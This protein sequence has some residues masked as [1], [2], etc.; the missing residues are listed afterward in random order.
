MKL[1]IVAFHQ[2]RLD[3]A[4]LI[5]V[6]IYSYY[7]LPQKVAGYYVIPYEFLNLCPSVHQQL[8]IRVHSIT[9]IPFEIITRNLAQIYSMTRQLQRLTKVSPPTFFC[10]IIPLCN[11]QDRNLVSSITLI[12]FEIISQ[13]L[14]EI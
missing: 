12:L 10:R 3:Q 9:L 8:I 14:V 5:D 1:Y 2:N 4:V 7:A 6:L 11:F 13:N